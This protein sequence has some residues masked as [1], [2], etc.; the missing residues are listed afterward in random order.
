[1]KQLQ[2]SQTVAWFENQYS[3]IILCRQRNDRIEAAVKYA[4]DDE[5]A[6]PPPGEYHLSFVSTPEPGRHFTFIMAAAR[7]IDLKRLRHIFGEDQ[8]LGGGT[9]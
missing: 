7:P 6:G 4:T 3:G 5:K 1:M 9:K 2:N 8:T